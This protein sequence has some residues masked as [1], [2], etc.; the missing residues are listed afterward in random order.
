MLSKILFILKEDFLLSVILMFILLILSTLV[1]L[2]SLSSIP[3]FLIAISDQNVFVSKFPFLFELI[4]SNVTN[5]FLILGFLIV[6]IFIIKNLFLFFVS[7]YQGLLRKKVREKIKKKIFHKYLNESYNFHLNHNPSNLIRNITHD[8]IHASD[9]LFIMLTILKEIFLLIS[10]F[11]LL[12]FTT[13]SSTLILVLLLSLA[14]YFF[15]FFVKNRIK[16]S[17]IEFREYTALEL[18]NLIQSFGSIKETKIFRRENYFSDIAEKNIRMI[19]NAKFITSVISQVPKLFLEIITISLIITII[20]IYINLGYEFNQILPNITLYTVCAL[21]MI[22]SFNTLTSSFTIFKLHSI[23]LNSI[24]NQLKFNNLQK[25]DNQTRNENLNEKNNDQIESIE[26][27]NLSFEYILNKKILKNIS[28]V[29]NKKDKIGILGKS[30]SGK[31]TFADI[32]MGLHKIEHG[33][34]LINNNDI[35]SNIEFWR[36]KIGYIPQNLYM[37]DDTIISNI[38]FGLTEKDINFEKFNNCLRISNLLKFVDNL[39]LKENTIIGNNGIRISGGEKQR[40]GIA[41]ALYNNPQLLIFDESTSALDKK[42]EEEI[43]HE[44]NNLDYDSIKIIISHKIQP[45]VNCNK[46]FLFENGRIF[47][48]SSLEDLK[49]N[50]NI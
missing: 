35:N 46:F 4:F 19:E 1:E 31:S 12:F 25:K 14:S 9:T 11:I 20:I 26:I 6:S 23:S 48:F 3:V 50:Y 22:P 16:N 24:Y 28:L 37:F 30:G 10:I 2:I 40:I 38:T 21:R 34:I 44:I 42:N 39:P 27:K 17:G 43:M 33:S 41:R 47:S 32:L 8:S 5:Y 7:Y 13:P 15:Y 29:I 18:K 45:L 49:K 36:S